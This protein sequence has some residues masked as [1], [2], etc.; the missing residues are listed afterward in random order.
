MR[1]LQFL[2]DCPYPPVSGA[3]IRNTMIARG[4][5]RLGTFRCVGLTP[6]LDP[7]H[8]GS[9]N[10]QHL[11]YQHLETFA[12]RNPWHEFDPQHPTEFFFSEASIQEVRK[13]LEDFSPDL[14]IVEGVALTAIL[15]IA[16]ELGIATVLDM[17]N[18]ESMLFAEAQQQLPLRKRI[19]NLFSSVPKLLAAQETD[20][21]GSRLANA[22]W[23]C[24]ETD[25]QQLREIDGD[26]SS[27]VPNPIPEVSLLDIPI[28]PERYKNPTSLFI[29][30][31]S[32]F[33]NVAAVKELVRTAVSSR[34]PVKL[35]V[36]GRSPGRNIRNMAKKGNGFA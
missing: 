22:T 36:A 18:I 5:G 15:R 35:V 28:T 24:S 21:E 30:H 17:H 27:V 10:Y 12:N 3:D 9:E 7:P 8:G 16:R 32:Y 14:V 11:N 2:I 4:A 1:V 13:L 34:L 33:P 26:A 6:R 20:R 19:R 23:V 31:L 29:G 25:Q